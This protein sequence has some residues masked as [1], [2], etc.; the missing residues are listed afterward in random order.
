VA[1]GDVQPADPI[2]IRAFRGSR[3]SSVYREHVVPADV[4]ERILE[5]AERG[6]LGRVSSLDPGGPDELDQ[7]E[8]QRLAHELT[9]L[10]AS[11]V[12]LDLDDDLTAFA[13]LAA[14]CG[15]A[16]EG[17]W[18]RVASSGGGGTAAGP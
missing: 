18:L 10:R 17:S 6:G 1:P 14:W 5:L 11:G 8:A 3:K 13:E 12:P 4:F 15:R 7:D 9:R 2:E 16:S